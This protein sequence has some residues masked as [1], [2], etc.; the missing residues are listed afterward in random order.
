MT[1]QSILREKNMTMYRL[2]QI[3]G[4]PKTTVIDICSGKSDIEGCTAKTVMQLSRALGCT[5]EELMQIDNA[6]YDRS[7]GLPK[8]ES[9]LEKGLPSYLQKSV[10]AMQA[11]W[12]IV[13]GGGKDQ[14]WDLYWGE[15]NADINSA[16]TEQEIS[17]D[18]AWYLRRKY[19]RMER[20]EH[21]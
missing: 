1:M 13:D 10:A 12:G 6:R 18:Q 16:E 20:D 3:S 5:M 11:S 17:S 14:H 15:L 9:Y 8:D 2:S 21:E 7:T 19:L 4:V